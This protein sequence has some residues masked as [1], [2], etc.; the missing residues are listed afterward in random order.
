[1]RYTKEQ[2]KAR[3]ESLKR[4]LVNEGYKFHHSAVARG[5]ESTE[6]AR[7]ESY[8][9]KFGKGKILHLPTLISDVRGNG[10][11]TILY[12]VEA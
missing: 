11:H 12:F 8:E 10:F 5:Y 6:G 1:M 4:H 2:L 9:G 3:F 7:I